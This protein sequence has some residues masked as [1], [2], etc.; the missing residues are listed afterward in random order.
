MMLSQF[1]NFRSRKDENIGAIQ[2]VRLGTSTLP[3]NT[4]SF[5]A[6]QPL[7]R[8]EWNRGTV[9]NLVN[10]YSSLGFDIN[11]FNIAYR[12]DSKEEYAVDYG[13][14]LLRTVTAA[15]TGGADRAVLTAFGIVID[16]VTD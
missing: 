11:P 8:K 10:G 4:N 1:E 3:V 7:P 15:V 12:A 6:V 13:Y 9:P 14:F 16:Q 2:S 5:T